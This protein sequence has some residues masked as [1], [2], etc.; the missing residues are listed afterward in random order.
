MDEAIKSE[1][2]RLHDEEGRQNHRLSDLEQAVK[3]LSDLVLNIQRLTISVESLTKEVQR[4]GER[5]EVIEQ[6]PAQEAVEW[7]KSDPKRTNAPKYQ[8]WVNA[9]GSDFDYVK[10][11]GD[12]SRFKGNG[13]QE[14][15]ANYIKAQGM[16]EAKQRVIW[17]DICDYSEK[18]WNKY[19]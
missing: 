5:L 12:L 16:S 18:N 9:G 14:K 19:F 10:T 7:F 17:F 1:F 6:K 13:K 4:Q 2:Q 15:I 11:R 3:E 8:A